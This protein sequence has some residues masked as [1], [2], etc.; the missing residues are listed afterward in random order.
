MTQTLPVDSSLIKPGTLIKAILEKTHCV[1]SMTKLSC[2]GKTSL[3]TQNEAVN[4]ESKG[5]V[6]DDLYCSTNED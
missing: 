2:A 1:Y 6:F 3:Q 4:S 5:H